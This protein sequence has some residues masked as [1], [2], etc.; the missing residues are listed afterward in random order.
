M[1][2]QVIIVQMKNMS[3]RNKSNYSSDENTSDYED[4]DPNKKG[5]KNLKKNVWCLHQL[6]PTMKR[7]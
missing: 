3:K 5:K 2:A 4:S 6:P 7:S 1:K